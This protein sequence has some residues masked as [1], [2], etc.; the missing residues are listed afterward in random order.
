VIARWLTLLLVMAVVAYL[1]RPVLAP[2]AIAAV[3]ASIVR[4]LAGTN[5]GKE[6]AGCGAPGQREGCAAL[7]RRGACGT[8]GKRS[9]LV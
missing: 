7:A 2:F 9:R 5:K 8:I 3:L 6:R 1:A 4:P